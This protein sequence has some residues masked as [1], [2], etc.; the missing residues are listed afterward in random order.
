MVVEKMM[1]EKEGSLSSKGEEGGVVEVVNL[2]GKQG[3]GEA[4]LAGR[5]SELEVVALGEEG[6]LL[7]LR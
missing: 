1:E 2:G 7:G 5:F 4:V 6:G 3:E